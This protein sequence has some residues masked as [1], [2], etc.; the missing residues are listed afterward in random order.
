MDCELAVEV[1]TEAFD[2]Y[3]HEQHLT[4][5]CVKAENAD[6]VSLLVFDYA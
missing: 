4:E 5:A 2:A 1:M 6:L 3:A